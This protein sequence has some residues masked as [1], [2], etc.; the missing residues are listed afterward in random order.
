MFSRRPRSSATFPTA[1]RRSASAKSRSTSSAE[2]YRCFGSALKKLITSGGASLSSAVCTRSSRVAGYSSC[3]R[4]HPGLRFGSSPIP[5]AM[6]ESYS[7]RSRTARSSLLR[8]GRRS[9][10]LLP[11]GSAHH[12]PPLFAY[13]VEVRNLPPV[14]PPEIA[15]DPQLLHS[16][17]EAAQRAGS[18]EDALRA[19]LQRIC[20]ATGWQAGRVEF[21]Q[22]ATENA[23]RTIW[24]LEQP[25]RLDTLKGVAERAGTAIAAGRRERCCARAGPSG[26]PGPRAERERGLPSR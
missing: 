26:A 10:T 13:P 12:P 24:Y 14:Q 16:V 21:A 1:N 17:R 5:L 25:D 22:R 20:A 6:S 19:A 7:A 8:R 4:C 2:A 11:G 9:V 3:A 18:L 23:P 15:R